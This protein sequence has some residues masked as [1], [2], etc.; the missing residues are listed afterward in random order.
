M[1]ICHTVLRVHPSTDVSTA[2][3]SRTQSS[4]EFKETAAS[5]IYC[6]Y[7]P[8]YISG[9]QGLKRKADQDEEEEDTSKRHKMSPRLAAKKTTARKSLPAPTIVAAAVPS[10]PTPVQ[11]FIMNVVSGQQAVSAVTGEPTPE[12]PPH[13]EPEKKVTVSSGLCWNCGYCGFVTHSQAFLKIHLNA[14]HHGKAH[15]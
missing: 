14:V 6:S 15:K 5:L 13:K 11:P 2:S 3:M 4:D 12:P 10:S 7:L 1:K 9:V 8:D